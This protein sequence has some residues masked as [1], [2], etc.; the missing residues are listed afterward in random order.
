MDKTM[1]LGKIEQLP[2]HILRELDDYV[3]FLTQKYAA[4]APKPKA[5]CM[6]G[7]FTWMSNDFNAPL[8]DFKDYQ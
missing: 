4:N 8:D 3:E 1:V 6:R 7:T 2:P 5:G